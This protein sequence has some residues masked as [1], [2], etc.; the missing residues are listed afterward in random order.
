[1]TLHDENGRIILYHEEDVREYLSFMG[2]IKYIE[3]IFEVALDNKY[4]K[5]A[6]LELVKKYAKRILE[7]A[8]E[9]NDMPEE[10]QEIFPSRGALSILE[11]KAKNFLEEK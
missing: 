3:G 7:L 5:E 8:K 11:I 1:M 10:K 2:E 6:S 4:P 9:Y